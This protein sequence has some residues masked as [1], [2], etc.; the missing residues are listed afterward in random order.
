[1]VG[2]NTQKKD[3][4]P[5][6]DKASAHEAALYR[7]ISHW[8]HCIPKLQAQVKRLEA[9]LSDHHVLL[10]GYT[11][12]SCLNDANI[13]NMEKL[14]SHMQAQ[15]QYLVAKEHL[16]HVLFDEEKAAGVT[17]SGEKYDWSDW[18]SFCRFEDPLNPDKDR[19]GWAMRPSKGI[20]KSPVH[21]TVLPKRLCVWR[22]VCDRMKARVKPLKARLQGV[23][24]K[25]EVK[26]VAGSGNTPEHL[27][28]L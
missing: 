21:P 1:M 23:R 8:V 24:E 9:W 12:A 15:V 16:L 7:N 2:D 13:A 22:R 27:D 6:A 3:K 19:K 26:V 4:E 17:E 28:G 10:E 20:T 18:E 25:D 11:S 14:S 5:V